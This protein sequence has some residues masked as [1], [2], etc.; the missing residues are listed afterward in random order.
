MPFEIMKK[1]MLTGIGLALKTRSEMEAL[2]KDIIKQS[3]MSEAEGRKFVAD[4][5]KKYERARTDMEKQI[6][7]GIAEYMAQ[8]DIAS[9]KELQALKQEVQ[10]LKKGAKTKK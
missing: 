2:T 4:V 3:K 6:K 10:R 8:A 5:M 9:K 7:K 1:V